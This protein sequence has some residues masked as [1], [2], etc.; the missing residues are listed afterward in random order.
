MR[1]RFDFSRI[2]V[3]VFFVVTAAAVRAQNGLPADLDDYAARAMKTFDVPGMALAI[4]KDGK[5][6]VAKGYGVRKLG[7]ATPVD[8]N[9]L[10]G[11]GSNSK[12]FKGA[13]LA[14]LVDESKNHWDE[15][16]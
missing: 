6:V 9:T 10:F 7:E 2:F 16:V 4:V 11:I 3:L 15:P 8:E 14:K 5:A 13:G 12:T 1:L